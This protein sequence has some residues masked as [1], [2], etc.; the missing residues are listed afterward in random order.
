MAK[1]FHTARALIAT[2]LEQEARSKFLTHAP[3]WAFR[4]V[5][6]AA[7]ITV[8]ALHSTV[9]PD[10]AP[11]DAHVLAQQAFAAVHRCSVQ[12]NDLPHRAGVII[13]TF[14]LFRG[15]LPKLELGACPWSS[16]L[17]VGFTYWCLDKFKV[18][19]QA[20]Q[21]SSDSATAN[22]MQEALRKFSSSHPKV[23]HSNLKLLV[24]PP[25]TAPPTSAPQPVPAD[26]PPFSQGQSIPNVTDPLQDIDWNMF[27]D[28]F[29]WANEDG[30]LLGLP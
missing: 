3:H 9:S 29:S 26:Q 2:V 30:V 11:N 20:A 1:A 7:C 15:L 12:E 14:W 13:E 8:S 10:M 24:E 6:D 17:S 25:S 18:G 19:L 22:K 16:R 4:I 27:M 21:R 28:D 5:V 23:D